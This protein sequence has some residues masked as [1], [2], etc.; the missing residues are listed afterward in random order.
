[1]SDWFVD[2]QE[3]FGLLRTD[4]FYG[5]V[6]VVSGQEIVGFGR[7]ELWGVDLRNAVT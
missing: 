6:P 5:S 2:V 1:M 4:L 3:V 7:D